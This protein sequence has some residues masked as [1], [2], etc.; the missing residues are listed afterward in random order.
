MQKGSVIRYAMAFLSPV[1]LFVGMTSLS[2]PSLLPVIIVAFL[3]L[4]LRWKVAGE[5]AMQ[6]ESRLVLYGAR[7]FILFCALLIFAGISNVGHSG[8]TGAQIIGAVI[9]LGFAIE[10]ARQVR[11]IIFIHG[12]EIPHD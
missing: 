11:R 3:Y 5:E 10:A 9:A 12:R 6:C 7:G 4:L 1:V 8:A 2:P